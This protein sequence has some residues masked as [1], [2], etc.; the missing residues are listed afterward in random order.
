MRKMTLI[1]AVVAGLAMAALVG[2]GT[3]TQTALA[4][5]GPHVDTGADSTPDK[6][7]SCHRIHS[8]QNEYLLKEAGSETDFCYSCHGNGG[9]G[10]DLAAQEG[11]FYGGTSAGDPYGSKTG[12]TDVGLRAGGFDTARIDT[13]D[14]ST[15]ANPNPAPAPRTSIGVL[16]STEPVVS[17]HAI[18]GTAGTMWGSGPIGSG[19]GEPSVTLGCGSCHNPHGNGNYRILRTEPT[20]AVGAG[21]AI[22]D[23]YPKAAADYTTADYFD[24]YLFGGVS[25]KPAANPATDPPPAG[26]SILWDTSNWCSQCHS[27]YLAAGGKPGA[28]GSRV[29]S[30][31]DIFTYR[32][33][34]A[35]YSVSSHG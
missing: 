20:G 6:C 18:D 21:Y 9:P 8:G 35:G 14:P 25:T 3:S 32:H 22:P 27:R 24:M 28:E 30:G 19:A 29:D 17:N 13:T 16:E 12:S 10:S 34:S 2:L 1:V 7:A 15:R 33:T 11:T 23:T 4:D 26:E 31:D 5:A